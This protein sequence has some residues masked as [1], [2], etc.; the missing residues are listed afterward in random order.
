MFAWQ[1]LSTTLLPKGLAKFAGKTHTCRGLRECGPLATCKNGE[2]FRPALG[3]R[4]RHCIARRLAAAR[5]D[6]YRTAD[7]HRRSP[8]RPGY[9]FR[10]LAFFDG[11]GSRGVSADNSACRASCSR[12]N[13]IASCNLLSRISRGGNSVRSAPRECR[14]HP[15]AAAARAPPTCR[16]TGPF[17]SAALHPADSR[18]FA[19]NEGRAPSVPYQRPGI[20]P[21]S[22]QWRP[23]A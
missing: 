4:P 21:V 1:R 18:A 9:F 14:Q 2:F 20:V 8:H 16:H 12:A 19:A 13:R 22:S 23:A 15:I 5:H 10:R 11:G 17:Q 6:G 3:N 7:R